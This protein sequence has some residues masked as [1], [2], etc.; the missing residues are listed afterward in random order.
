MQNDT[1]SIS[2]FSLFL[3]VEQFFHAPS[4]FS[5]IALP[6]STSRGALQMAQNVCLRNK[7]LRRC[8]AARH[9]RYQTIKRFSAEAPG[10]FLT[11]E[12]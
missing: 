8:I 4:H 6:E 10:R 3:C 12:R 5:R 11:E 9:S 2:S 7:N 1:D